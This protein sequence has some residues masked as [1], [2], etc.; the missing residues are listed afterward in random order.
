MKKSILRILTGLSALA[1]AGLLSVVPSK[2]AEADAPRVEGT[3][4][5]SGVD[6]YTPTH[7]QIPASVTFNYS[8]FA[9]NP[10]TVD[11]AEFFIVAIGGNPAEYQAEI[12]FNGGYNYVTDASGTCSFD[13]TYQGNRYLGTVTLNNQPD[14]DY[15]IYTDHLLLSSFLYIEPTNQLSPEELAQLEAMLRFSNEINNKINEIG[16]AAQGL[17]ADGSENPTKT[18]EYSCPGALDAGIMKAIANTPGVTFLYTYAYEGIVFRSTIT[19]E[20]AQKVISDDI[21]WYGPCF[22]AENFPTVIVGVA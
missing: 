12:H 20:L 10:V 21:P 13:F 11:R 16:K 5:I 4:Q 2:T 7:T 6:I 1:I 18:V 3:Y 8:S 9:S 19:S 22:L 14:Y 15:R 17:N